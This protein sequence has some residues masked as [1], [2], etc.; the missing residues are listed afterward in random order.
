M[1]ATISKETITKALSLVE[2]IVEKTNIT[3]IVKY[4]YRNLRTTLLDW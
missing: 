4:S 1:K 3:N 2:G